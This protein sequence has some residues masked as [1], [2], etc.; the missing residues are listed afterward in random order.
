[1]T[2]IQYQQNA[3]CVPCDPVREN[4]DAEW[5]FVFRGRVWSCDK[6]FN[7]AAMRSAGVNDPGQI[8]Q[9]TLPVTGV[10]AEKSEDESH[11]GAQPGTHEEWVRQGV[12]Q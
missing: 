4:W 1:V 12:A 2:V 5:C 11:C 9:F 10:R 6:L 8:S 3:V 7:R